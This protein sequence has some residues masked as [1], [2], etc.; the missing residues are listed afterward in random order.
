MPKG[1]VRMSIPYWVWTVRFRTDESSG[2]S[3]VIATHPAAAKR[4]V[5][6][7]VDGIETFERAE[8]LTRVSPNV[9]EQHFDGYASG[10]Q[11]VLSGV[12]TARVAVSQR[13]D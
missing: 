9:A 5:A 4:S 12:A 7:A 11:R 13:G 3:T 2:E 8:A 6:S 1:V 10:L